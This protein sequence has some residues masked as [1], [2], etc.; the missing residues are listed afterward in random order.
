MLGRQRR[1]ERSSSGKSAEQIKEWWDKGTRAV[2]REIDDYRVNVAFLEDDQWIY[3]NPQTRRIEEYVRRDK[4]RVRLTMNKLAPNTRTVMGLLFARPLFFEVPPTA[5]D[6]ATVAAARLG[7]QILDHY[8]EAQ[9]WETVREMNGL[10]AWA[11]GTSAIVL[12]WDPN[13][14][15]LVND[16]GST[17]THEGDV[18]LDALAMGEFVVTPGSRDAQ[19]AR[20][21]IKGIAVPVDQAKEDYDLSW[22]PKA[23]THA[24]TLPAERRSGDEN[25][26]LCTVYTLYERPS[27]DGDGEVTIV[28]GDTVVA[29]DPWPFPFD[30]HLNLYVARETIRHSRWAGRTILTSARSPQVAFNMSHSSIQEHMKLAGNARTWVPWET[31][32]RIEE[33]TDTPGEFVPYDGEAGKPTVVSPPQMPTW[34]IQ[35]PDRLS[36]FIDEQLGTTEVA[37]G[38]A[39]RNVESG[40]GLMLLSE[41]AQSPLA[42]LTKEDARVWSAIAT[43]VLRTL[44]QHVTE[45]RTGAYVN[46]PHD[47]PEEFRYIGADLKGQTTARVPLE[48]IAIRSRA[49]VEAWANAQLAGGHIT[50]GQFVRLIETPLYGHDLEVLDP[51]AD[52]QRRENVRMAKGQRCLPALFDNHAVHI[53]ELNTFRKSQA[54]ETLPPAAKLEFEFHAVAHEVLAAREAAKDSMQQAIDPALAAAASVEETPGTAPPITTGDLDEGIVDDRD[55]P[56]GGGPLEAGG[57]RVGQGPEVGGGLPQGGVPPILMR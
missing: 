19:K 18:V 47:L 29:S 2:R 49:Q 50:F 54:F 23:D 45:E 56:G 55:R 51:D 17:R 4:D 24:S 33:L 9:G 57:E 11:G 39:P 32:N 10:N 14:G 22:T 26:N 34:W 6:D 28:I 44:E 53:T 42:H 13:A 37:R 38:V 16:E 36:M 27:S 40:S 48:A 1:D 7:V 30:D 43:D 8:H 15:R 3:M 21:W 12:D 41:N 31:Y 52:K 25:A 35:Q 5:A 46:E 20:R